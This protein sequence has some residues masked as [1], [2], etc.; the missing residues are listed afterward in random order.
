VTGSAKK[1]NLPKPPTPL[2][3]FGQ[4]MATLAA[5]VGC[6]EATLRQRLA[7]GA[8]K[9]PESSDKRSVDAWVRRF[10]KWTNAQKAKRATERKVTNQHDADPDAAVY[11][12][13]WQRARSERAQL[14]LDERR[15]QVV[16]R[17]EVVE[18]ASR[19]ILTVRQRLN[20]MVQ[21]MQSR[22]ENVAGH[23]VAEELQDEV[24]SMCNAFARGMDQMLPTDEDNRCFVCE[25]R[26]Q[27]REAPAK[28]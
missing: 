6:H 21:K 7:L 9:P 27:E 5:R 3:R 11:Q 12:R 28:R 8:P 20:S 10:A 18:F 4:S 22:L 26:N 1:K 14:E 2:T 25:F 16:S 17:A 13:N 24:D 15:Q 19:A 23:V